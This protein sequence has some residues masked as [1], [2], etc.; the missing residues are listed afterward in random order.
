VRRHATKVVSGTADYQSATSSFSE[1]MHGRDAS[2]SSMDSTV[3]VP[4]V[5]ESKGGM[6]V[7]STDPAVIHAITQ[8]MIGE[9]LF[10]YTRR[11]IGKGQSGNR[12]PRYFW[13]HPYTKTLYWG[14][15][16]PGSSVASESKAKSGESERS[17]LY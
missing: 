13:I 8:T 9:Y 4:S 14:E 17:G 11:A 15:E 7:G 12:H 3:P 5:K 2:I 1:A 6:E 10:K 16:D